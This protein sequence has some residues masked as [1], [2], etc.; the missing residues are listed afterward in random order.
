MKTHTRKASAG[1]PMTA[2]LLPSPHRFLEEAVAT[3]SHELR[4]P[5]SAIKGY[6]T[7]LIR[8]DRHLTRAE[9]IE[10][11]AALDTASDRMEQLIDRLVR[12]TQLSHET[13]QIRQEP[14]DLTA[15]V[16]EAIASIQ[17][18]GIPSKTT[19][20]FDAPDAPMPFVLGDR[21]RM[22]E[23]VYHLIENAILYSPNGG[24]I[25][26]TIQPI[27]EASALELCVSDEGIGI[28]VEHQERIFD[29]FHRVDMGL[30]REVSGIGLG[31]AY[32]KRVVEL[33]GGTIRV[34]SRPGQG[35]SFFLSLPTTPND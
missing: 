22:S 19:I 12:M 5:L 18:A 30:T 13:V 11:L 6:T 34:K 8:H 10:F 9:R 23:V 14:L 32:C 1:P 21:Q 20:T 16:H 17:Q 7:T 25:T 31:L 28:P 35:S 2:P 27:H 24:A 29:P 26:L 3:L 4:T 15:I 33:L